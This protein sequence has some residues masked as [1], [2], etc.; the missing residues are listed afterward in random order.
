M[1]SVAIPFYNQ[2]RF[3]IETLESVLKQKTDFDYEIV[4]GDDCSTD[5]SCAILIDFQKKH[6]NKIRVIFNNPNL[7]L[8]L[9]IGNI[10]D[11]CRGKYIALL[12]GDDL[13][14]SENKLQKQY[15]FI[16]K[17]QSLV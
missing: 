12:G 1:V 6:P 13:F 7:G 11:N 9:N 16:E 14:A 5:N 8:V 4:A 3:I 15:N 10:L 17:T 2:E